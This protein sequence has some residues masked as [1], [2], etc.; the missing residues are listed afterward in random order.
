MAPGQAVRVARFLNR[1]PTWSI[2]TLQIFKPV[3]RHTRS[4]RGELQQ[5][6]FSLGRPGTY[7]L[8]EPLDDLV[9]FLV[10]A[11]IRELGPVVPKSSYQHFS[12]TVNGKRECAHVYLGHSTNQQFKFA[13]IKHIY[14]VSGNE[15]Q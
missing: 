14:Q 4:T 2:R 7:A 8:P 3:N 15:F 1:E 9:G 12:K 6:R 5:A 10:A 11:V 13:F